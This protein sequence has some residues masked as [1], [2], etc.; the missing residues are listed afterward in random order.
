MS[1]MSGQKMWV[2]VGILVIIGGA[3]FVYLDP[4]DLDLLSLKKGSVVVQPAAPPRVAAPAAK[5]G[6]AAPA[7]QPTTAAPKAAIASA[8]AN[9]PAV[10]A[11]AAPSS[12]AAPVVTPSPAVTPVVAAP[13]ATPAVAAPSVA[14][15]GQALQPPL[16][17][18]KT[19]KT[20]KKPSQ[21]GQPAGKPTT[22]KPERAKN[23]DLRNCLELET[24]AA[25]AKC[26]GE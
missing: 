3:A 18:A 7:A 20:A 24:D 25:I 9:A 16:K 17:L 2:L 19:I 11:P 22:S 6:V 4:L 10:A 23:L 15:Q 12:T 26:A 5:P 8:Q 13:V 1:I 21:S 14:T